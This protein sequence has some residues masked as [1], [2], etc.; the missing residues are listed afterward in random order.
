MAASFFD[1]PNPVTAEEEMEAVRARMLASLPSA[2]HGQVDEKFSRLR[3]AILP[4]MQQSVDQKHR[5]ILDAIAEEL[6][7]AG[8]PVS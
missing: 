4:M 3:S 8:V 5:Q 1:I 2:F 6:R 7:A